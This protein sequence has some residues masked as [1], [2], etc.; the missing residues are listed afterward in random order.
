L[1]SVAAA[2]HACRSVIGGVSEAVVDTG[3]HALQLRFDRAR[4]SVAD[5]VRFLEDFGLTVTAVAQTKVDA[6]MQVASA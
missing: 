3:G 6:G 1:P 4:A 5:I 2:A